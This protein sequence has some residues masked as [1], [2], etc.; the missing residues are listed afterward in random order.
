MGA[1]SN[2]QLNEKDALT[3][4]LIAKGVTDWC[5]TLEY[6]K[7]LPYGRNTNRHDLSLVLSEEKGTCSSKHAFIKRIADLNRVPNVKLYI[8]IYKMNAKN[9]AGVKAVL[10]QY[11]L[12]YIPEAHCY[13]EIEG[14]RMDFTFASGDFENIKSDLLKEIE[15]E[16]GQVGEFKVGFHKEYVKK[17]LLEFN[18]TAKKPYAF[19]EMWKIRE[20]CIKSLSV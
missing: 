10:D 4:A 14:Q 11:Q 16:P 19:D 17:W 18:K 1:V 15:I 20:K 12:N 13:L 7:T 5:A 3:Q 9:T 2:Y 8:G 6:V